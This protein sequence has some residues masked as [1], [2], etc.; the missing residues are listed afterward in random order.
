MITAMLDTLLCCLIC[1]IVFENNKQFSA[2][3]YTDFTDS[4]E[5]EDVS[6]PARDTVPEF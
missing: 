4:S 5:E 2:E 3:P 1:F 6:A